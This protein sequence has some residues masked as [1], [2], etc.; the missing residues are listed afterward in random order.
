MQL[1]TLPFARSCFLFSDYFGLTSCLTNL[2]FLGGG[3]LWLWHYWVLIVSWSFDSCLASL[4]YSPEACGPSFFAVIRRP[5][6]LCGRLHRN[7]PYLHRWA[8]LSKTYAGRCDAQQMDNYLIMQLASDELDQ[9]E[10]WY[11][12]N[13][14]L[15]TD[16]F[17]RMRSRLEDMYPEYIVHTNVSWSPLMGD[18]EAGFVVP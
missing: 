12:S 8:R 2:L 17:P 1:S 10:T 4:H 18:A 16:T 15:E 6:H 13:V 7:C 5:S 9:M 3:F 14:P 11:L